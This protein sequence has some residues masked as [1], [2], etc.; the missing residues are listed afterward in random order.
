MNQN[1]LI[2]TICCRDGGRSRGRSRN[3]GRGR[4]G[5]RNRDRAGILSFYCFFGH[6]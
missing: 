3:R 2:S 6:G 4:D 5:D 1:V